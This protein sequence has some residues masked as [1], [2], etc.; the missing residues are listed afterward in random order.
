MNIV[1]SNFQ[2]E[3]ME[4]TDRV[5]VLK[6]GST[7][8]APCKRLEQIIN[9]YNSDKVKVCHV[10]ID[11]EIE[12]AQTFN[13]SSVPSTFIYKGGQFQCFL[14]GLFNEKKL[15]ECLSSVGVVL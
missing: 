1:N 2:K 13:I 9:K 10:N 12:L 6:F 11:D 14:G 7:T 3:V 5:V 4:E 15:I 8:C